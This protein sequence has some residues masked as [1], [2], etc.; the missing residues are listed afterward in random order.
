MDHTFVEWRRKPIAFVA[1]GNVGGAR[2]VEQ[3]R[4]VAVEFEMTP[5]RH[6]VHILPEV[7]LAAPSLRS[8]L[9]LGIRAA[10]AQA[11]PSRR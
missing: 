7:F 9:R 11:C 4:L 5:L 3:L 2:A 6:A 10:E 1:W 8:G